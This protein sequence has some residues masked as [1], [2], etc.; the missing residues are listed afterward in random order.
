MVE[1]FALVLTGITT[2][3]IAS[4]IYTTTDHG[5]QT[6]GQYR[7]KGDALYIYLGTILLLGLL[8]PLIYGF[9]ASFTGSVALT[10]PLG[11]VLGGGMFM[12]NETVTHW[13]HT[14]EKSL[15][16]YA[17]SVLLVVI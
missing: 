1:A 17:S 5:F 8:N 13:K 14:D 2:A 12:V 7:S 6:G 9:W 10:T 15:A 4:L 11:L 16:I 3:F